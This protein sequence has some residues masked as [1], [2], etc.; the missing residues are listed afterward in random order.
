MKTI[1][2]LLQIG[3]TALLAT[4]L[5]PGDASAHDHL[6]AGISSPLPSAPLVLLNE[7]DYGGSSGFVFNL[8]AGDPGS[9]YDGFYYMNDLVFVAQAA[10]PDYGGPEPGAAGLGSRIAA[11]LLSVDG[12]TGAH[13][14]FWET[15]VDEV[16]STN[17]TWSVTVPYTGGT[18]LILVTQSPSQPKA[19]PYGHLHGRIYSVDQ[20]GFYTTTWRFVDASTNG[21]GG[22]PVQSPSAPFPLFFQADLTIA[23]IRKSSE[24]VEVIFAAP[25][26]IP[27]SGIGPATQYTLETA[28]SL[29]TNAVW[30]TVGATVSG[31]D[32][33]H[34]NT[35]TAPV[36]PQFFRLRSN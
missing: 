2:R 14:G 15:L 20:P 13:L 22:G 9:P 21:P 11:Q 10:T 32:H 28:P 33:L 7:A 34:T 17:L 16:D 5:V 25:S 26:N 12:P 19:D 30:K 3:L 36:A 24:N 23:G 31:D 4:S 27:D 1:Q 35:V 18:N 6:E 29:A 8:G